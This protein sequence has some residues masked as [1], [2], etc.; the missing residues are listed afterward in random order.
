M[1]SNACPAGK[2]EA[3]LY[4]S[5]VKSFFLNVHLTVQYLRKFKLW[6]I[7]HIHIKIRPI[8]TLQSAHLI[9]EPLVVHGIRTD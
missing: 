7:S 2:S 5:M 4:F 1:D 3:K 9:I 6:N 8:K